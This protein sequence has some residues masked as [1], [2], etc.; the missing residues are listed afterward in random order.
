MK[1]PKYLSYRTAGNHHWL[2]FSLPL[3]KHW[4]LIDHIHEFKHHLCR[5]P[6]QFFWPNTFFFG[7]KT[8]N[9]LIHTQTHSPWEHKLKNRVAL[10]LHTRVKQH[11]SFPQSP[12]H[13]SGGICLLGACICIIVLLIMK[14][15]AT[16]K[17]MENLSVLSIYVPF[18][19]L[20]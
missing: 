3:P 14:N 19:W 6:I 12:A 15:S 11:N 10:E 16:G 9:H 20:C 5:Y 2:P 1:D 4:Y 8:S 17:D 7:M 13:S 18:V